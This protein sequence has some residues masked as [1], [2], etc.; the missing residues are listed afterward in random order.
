MPSV[1]PAV[2]SI[3]DSDRYVAYTVVSSTSVFSVPFPVFGAGGDIQVFYNGV[4]Q[5]G[6][7]TFS[8]LSGNPLP[9]IPLPIADG[10]VTLNTAITSGT[11]EIIGDWRP[12]QGILDTSPSLNRREYQQDLGQ[13]VASLREMWATIGE[14]FPMSKLGRA[15]AYLGFDSQ[16]NAEAIPFVGANAPVSSAMAPVVD[17][18]TT[19]AALTL[20]GF[21]SYFQTLISA[22]NGTAFF[23]GIGFS[24]IGATIATAANAAAVLTALGFSTIGG[25]IAAAANA[26]AVMTAQGF[27]TFFQTLVS[28]TN[29]ASL[30]TTLG[31]STYHQTLL[32]PTTAG[33]L[34]NLIGMGAPKR[35][36]VLAGP[37]DGTTGLPAFLPATSGT[38]SVTSQNVTSGAPFVVTAAGG[39]ASGGA[40][41]LVGISTTNLTWS[42]LTANQTNYLY[43][44]IG[45]GGAL[46]A[47]STTVPPV[48]QQGG[49]PSITANALTFNIG[50]MT[51]YLGNGSTAPAAFV[52][53]VGEAVTNSSA[54]TSTVMYAYNGRY[55][56][57]SGTA[58]P[59]TSAQAT[60]THSLGVPPVA[61]DIGL[62]LLCVTGNQSY[63]AGMELGGG[64]AGAAGSLAAVDRNTA[65]FSTYS[66]VTIAV[67]PYGGGASANITNADWNLRL[68][69]ERNF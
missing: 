25:T 41:D 42:G 61:Y 21:S 28:A 10:Q 5:I 40:N 9:S 31:F 19:G 45:S 69:A 20:M 63:T 4:A 55:V 26:A 29:A 59:G 7:W 30:L 43:V 8:S 2:P 18:A 48:Y 14:T 6:N 37:A 38:L 32:S 33:G 53:L 66:S 51:M 54:V 35:Q 16:G 58:I 13:A 17:A 3:G 12:R 49:S 46:T 22:A 15:N 67:A 39:G 23:T 52:V 56:S 57:P 36:T 27:S 44:T 60:L 47:G 24:A 68:I 64:P 1:P 65:A 11:L 34:L 62:R 50:Q